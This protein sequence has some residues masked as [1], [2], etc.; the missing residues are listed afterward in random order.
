MNSTS[1]T[2][3][4]SVATGLMLWLYLTFQ[5]GCKHSGAARDSIP[6]V[7]DSG[8]PLM[9]EHAAF[10]I[11]HYDL[12]I[13]IDPKRRFVRGEATIEFEV[14]K[15]MSALVLDLDP[16]LRVD[17]VAVHLAPFPDDPSAPIQPVHFDHR[18]ARLWVYLTRTLRP[19][20]RAVAEITSTLT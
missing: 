14:L 1:R 6:E 18:D 16:R 2:R 5:T 4:F 20:E 17:A 12:A 11:G 13:A 10:D 3:L 19:G 15:T 8:G 7:L 9:A